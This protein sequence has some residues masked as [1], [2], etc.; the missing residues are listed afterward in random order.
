[1][2]KVKLF[3]PEGTSGCS[4]DGD[5]Y[6]VAEDGTVDVPEKAIEALTS[7]GFAT[8]REEAGKP[9]VPAATP[10]AMADLAAKLT[11]AKAEAAQL[12]GSLEG[13]TAERD[14]LTAQLEAAK[15]RR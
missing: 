10:E 8:S 2:A 13:M 12:R 15:K 4:F 6:K 11:A 14:G 7:H 9:L 3:A 5:E 1:V